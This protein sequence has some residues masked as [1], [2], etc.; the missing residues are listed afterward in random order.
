MLAPSTHVRINHVSPQNKKRHSLDHLPNGYVCNIL[1]W[2]ANNPHKRARS[3]YSCKKFLASLLQTMTRKNKCENRL[4]LLRKVVCNKKR[5][6]VFQDFKC[7]GS[8]RNTLLNIYY[9]S[10]RKTEWNECNEFQKAK[11]EIGDNHNEFRKI[12]AYYL[13]TYFYV[14]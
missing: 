10:K 6:T 5:L 13:F 11:F 7:H 14:T 2:G 1:W 3:K 8:Y 12:S 9:S 4:R